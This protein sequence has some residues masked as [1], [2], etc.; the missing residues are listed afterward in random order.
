MPNIVSIDYADPVVRAHMLFVQIALAAIKHADSKFYREHQLS[1]IK[2]LALKILVLNGGTLKHS[3]LARWT[4]TKKHNITTLVDRMKEDKF[5]T[6]ER[7]HKDKRVIDITITDKGRETYEKANPA[8]RNIIKELM[9][10]ISERDIHNFEK[11]LMKI[12]KNIEKF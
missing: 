6:T 11:V 4:N 2:Y 8:A 1:M 10:G 5:V 7:S 3:E 12:K 9:Q